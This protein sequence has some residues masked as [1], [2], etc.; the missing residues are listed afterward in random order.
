V[1][2]E[3]FWGLC[4][5]CMMQ[6]V[7]DW[8]L[9]RHIHSELSADENILGLFSIADPETGTYLARLVWSCYE[10][11]MVYA[12]LSFVGHAKSWIKFG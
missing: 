1:R 10:E 7:T 4:M 12:I 6:I 8:D 11:I 9:L 2:I 5:R 3:E